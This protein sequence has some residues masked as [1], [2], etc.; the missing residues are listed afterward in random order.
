[1]L[2]RDLMRDGRLAWPLGWGG[3]LART[4]RTA[5]TGDDGILEDVTTTAPELIDSQTMEPRCGVVITMRFEGRS[6]AEALYWDGPANAPTP[7]RMA[8][9][10]RP[11]I[12]IRI[13]DLHELDIGEAAPPPASN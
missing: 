8:N 10:L 11:H 12:G 4:G 6:Y 3:A 5:G 7:E 13:G 9:K 1:M 2:L